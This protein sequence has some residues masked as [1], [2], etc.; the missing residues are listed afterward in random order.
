MKKIN[1]PHNNFS[2]FPPNAKEVFKG[3]RWSILQWEQELFDGSKT[4]FES[5]MRPDTVT[6]FPIID[7]KIVII[8]EHQ[9]QWKEKGLNLISGG[10]EKGES[11]YESAKREVEEETGLV[12]KDYF[13]VRAME[14]MPGI[15]WNSYIFIAKNL[16]EKVPPTPEPGEKIMA[17]E[18]SFEELISLT[19]EKKFIYRPRLVEE[20]I[21]GD[22][23]KG[24]K[25]IFLNPENHT[26]EKVG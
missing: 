23:I 16:L 21:I 7:D 11:V 25:D 13:L 19:R 26:L 2:E 12:F 6:I 1:S 3:K 17:K 24:L 22:D 18:V 10:V 8:E 4:I 20:Y 5:V 15:F 9:P 14:P